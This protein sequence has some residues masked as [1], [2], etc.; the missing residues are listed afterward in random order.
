MAVFTLTMGSGVA[1]VGG[2]VTWYTLWHRKLATSFEKV[3]VG[4]GR[5]AHV[6]RR[7]V[8]LGGGAD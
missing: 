6:L 5:S 2:F 3:S 4:T 8:S 1:F 7:G